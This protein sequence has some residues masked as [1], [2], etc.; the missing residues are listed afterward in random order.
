MYLGPKDMPFIY[1]VF[2]DALFLAPMTLWY[3]FLGRGLSLASRKRLALPRFKCENWIFETPIY[4]TFKD[5]NKMVC[6]HGPQVLFDTT[7]RW[8]F[9]SF[10]VNIFEEPIY[11]TFKDVNE[12]VCPRSPRSPGAIRHDRQTMPFWSFFGITRACFIPAYSYKRPRPYKISSA[13]SKMHLG[14]KNIT[15]FIYLVLLD[16]LFLAP[17]TLC[18]FFLGRLSFASRKRL[19]LPRFKCENWATWLALLCFICHPP[20][21]S[22]VPQSVSVA[23]LGER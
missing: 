6:P 13:K 21:V 20:R 3:F 4:S 23:Q 15:P 17:M 2:L 11:F 18:S 16:V 14:P 10:F 12:I 22:S 8:S 7:A 19:A 1:L 9:W 5:M